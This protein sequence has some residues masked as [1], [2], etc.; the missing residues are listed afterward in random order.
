MDSIFPYTTTSKPEG[1]TLKVSCSF[2][3]YESELDKF[4]DWILPY[5]ETSDEPL[6]YYRLERGQSNHLQFI[7]ARNIWK[8][9]NH[10]DKIQE[11]TF[12]ENKG[13]I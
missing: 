1:N 10:M 7:G 13:V 11:F 3:N 2:R 8:N 12:I 9:I 6:G 4:L 5:C